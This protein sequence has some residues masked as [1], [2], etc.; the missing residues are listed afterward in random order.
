M[1]DT[2]DTNTVLAVVIP[3]FFS[4]LGVYMATLSHSIITLLLFLFKI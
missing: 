2:Q 4:L 3:R 1:T